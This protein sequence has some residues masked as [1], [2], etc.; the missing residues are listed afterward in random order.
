METG[1]VKTVAKLQNN[2]DV[3]T[4]QIRKLTLN[5][6]SSA[7]FMAIVSAW[8]T[9]EYQTKKTYKQNVYQISTGSMSAY[10]SNHFCVDYGRMTCIV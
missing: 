3:S 5:N 10:D 4:M 1:M 7:T 8:P 9:D 6:V 2:G